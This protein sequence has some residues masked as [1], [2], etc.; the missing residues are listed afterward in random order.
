[1]RGIYVHVPYCASRCGYCDFN[2]YVAPEAERAGFAALAVLEV[3]QA[4][5]AW[6]GPVET[7]F[8]GGGTPTML[9]PEDLA[10]ILDGVRER[11]GL[12]PGAEVTVEANPESVDARALATLRKAG[13]TRV[14]FGMQSAADHVL[15]TLDRRHTPG[16]AA[17]AVTDARAAGFAHVS[18][19]LIYGTPGE[20]DADWQA[21]LDAVVAAQP[22]HASAYPLVV[23]RGTKL[24]AR[25]RRG[26]LPEPDAEA[27][28]RR[29]AMADEAFSGAGLRWYELY[30]WS[31]RGS[32][33]R[34]NLGYWRGGDWWGIGPGA[35][36]HVDGVR[37]WNVRR[38]QEYAARLR[39]GRSPEAGREHLDD[40]ARA[41]ER[42]MLGVRL[43]EG[44]ELTCDAVPA[45]SAEGLLAVDGS[46]I[47]LTLE[48]R[49]AADRVVLALA[50]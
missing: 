5:E 37:W 36:G 8:F 7:V 44:L 25:V 28:A 29:Y 41:L 27:Q 46:R 23:E 15:A 6:P 35:H 4:A 24:H 20:S 31:L 14:S 38:P 32:E 9:A 42:V 18:L 12:V 47:A 50:G 30:N 3:A 26:E 1:M 11:F 39:D 22:D 2:T 40:S 43:R 10:A 33:C 34:H 45:L 13:F 49:R 21:S 17:A 48:G 16:R 19:D